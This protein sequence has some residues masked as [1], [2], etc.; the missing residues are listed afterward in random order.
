MSDLEAL[1][2]SLFASALSDNVGGVIAFALLCA[3][4]LA[5]LVEQRRAWRLR[6]SKRSGNLFGPRG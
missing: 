6:R 1:V 2:D 3:G 4:G 5:W